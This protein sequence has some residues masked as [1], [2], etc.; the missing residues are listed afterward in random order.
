MKDLKNLF[1]ILILFSII[2]VNSQSIEENT[3][4]ELD[5]LRISYKVV[6]FTS[7]E[8]QGTI[9]D[10]YEVKLDAKNISNQDIIIL[11][12]DIDETKVDFSKKQNRS[13]VTFNCLNA[14]G[15]RLT[16]KEKQLFL[17]PHRIRYRFKSYDKEGET[18]VITKYV[19]TAYYLKK[20][21]SVSDDAIFI[22]PKGEKLKI[23]YAEVYK[24]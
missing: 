16:A 13:L 22:V 17:K 18:K 6:N 19:I 2:K 21:E 9:Y 3:P 20:G 12:G 23:T 10:R 4:I 5:K 15:K 1:I 14:N 8:I 7:K 24:N 11:E